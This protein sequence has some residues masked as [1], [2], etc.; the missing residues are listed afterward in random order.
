MLIVRLRCLV[1]GFW[2]DEGR[3]RRKREKKRRA[4]DSN[5]DLESQL[6]GPGFSHHPAHPQWGY[7]L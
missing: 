2:V 3:K 4:P 6:K 1:L 5:S 7:K